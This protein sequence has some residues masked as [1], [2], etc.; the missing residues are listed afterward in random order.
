MNTKYK[1]IFIF[2][3][4]HFYLYII[5]LSERYG[6]HIKIKIKN[7]TF[8]TESIELIDFKFDNEYK[9]QINIYF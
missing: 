6:K 4:K 1:S 3:K 9:I 7:N 2:E 8:F 5:I